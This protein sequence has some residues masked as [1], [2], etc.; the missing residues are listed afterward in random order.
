MDDKLLIGINSPQVH[1]S[2]YGDYFGSN[3]YY[4]RELIST[5]KLILR[6]YLVRESYLERSI[7]YSRSYTCWEI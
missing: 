3:D 7:Y 5:N 4:L 6:P 1:M 2:A